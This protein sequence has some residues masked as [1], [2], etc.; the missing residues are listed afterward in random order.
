MALALV[1]MARGAVP[2]LPRA[3]VVGE[4][5]RRARAARHR[6]Q[7]GAAGAAPN[8]GQRGS[9]ARPGR[10]RSNIAVFSQ[11]SVDA[12]QYVGVLISVPGRAN[13]PPSRPR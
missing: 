3:M 1:T 5:G 13:S 6:Q 12:A 11:R 10:R 9:G 8:V 4:A 7:R 2:R